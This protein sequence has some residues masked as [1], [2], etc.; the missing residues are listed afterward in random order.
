VAKG[1]AGL[2][3]KSKP[4]IKLI[5][6]QKPLEEGASFSKKIWHWMKYTK[7]KSSEEVVGEAAK[8]MR[9]ACQFGNIAFSL[10]A[11]GLVIPKL[12]RGK[13]NKEREKELKDRGIDQSVID[14][15]YPTFNMNIDKQLQES[16]TARLK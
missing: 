5:N 11:L 15:Y 10:I 1:I 2:I 14:K 12:Y 13:T 8:K 9:S 7:L 6:D 3:Q 4:E 16:F